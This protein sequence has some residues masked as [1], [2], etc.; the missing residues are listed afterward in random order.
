MKRLSYIPIVALLAAGSLPVIV[1][2]RQSSLQ[3]V[4]R[5]RE[6]LRGRH[7]L[8]ALREAAYQD[9]EGSG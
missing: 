7:E 9:E 4:V 1:K 3:A 8:D 2:V 6:K 5:G